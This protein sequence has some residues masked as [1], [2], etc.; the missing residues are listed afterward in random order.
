[1][2]A[3][4]M[5]EGSANPSLEDTAKAVA[6]YYWDTLYKPYPGYPA[7]RPAST[8]D[9]KKIFSDTFGFIEYADWE[10]LR[11]WLKKNRRTLGKKL[12]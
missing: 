2:L 10:G 6:E 8:T 11:A 1:M 4:G 9:F 5:I 12:E 7:E 3:D